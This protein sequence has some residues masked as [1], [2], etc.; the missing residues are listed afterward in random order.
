MS[1]LQHRRSISSCCSSILV[2]EHCTADGR[3]Q[4]EMKIA[5][6]NRFFHQ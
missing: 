5:L 4:Y 6:Y 3:E 2:D 1:Y